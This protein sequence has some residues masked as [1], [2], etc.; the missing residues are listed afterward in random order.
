M[1]IVKRFLFC[2]L[3]CLLLFSLI[4]AVHD[5]T[6]TAAEVRWWS[7]F[8]EPEHGGTVD[9][10][11]CGRLSP[12]LE[13][14]A[15]TYDQWPEELK[16]EYRYN[17]EKARKILAEA[18]YPDGFQTVCTASSNSDLELLQ[19]VKSQFMDIGID[20]SIN[21]MDM[22]GFTR[23]IMSA[24]HE[25]AGPSP[26]GHGV[27]SAPWQSFSTSSQPNPSTVKDP[28]FDSMVME[29]ED[30]IDPAELSK[31]CI[32][33]DRYFVEHHWGTSFFPYVSYNIYQPYLKGYSGEN[34]GARG[35]MGYFARWWISQGG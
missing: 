32:E 25:V 29:L 14:Y 18:G 10:S 30:I 23:F 12:S 27:T 22:G 13:G 20:M 15:F 33:V 21:T 31:K 35:N 19:I 34:I 17:P 1:S 3:S 24:K 26:H 5:V 7:E 9:G 6:E 4:L 2:F 28:V 8:G 11:P 16:D